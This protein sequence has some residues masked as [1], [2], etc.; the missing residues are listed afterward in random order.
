M[1]GKQKHA[2]FQLGQITLNVTS[3]NFQE[4]NNVKRHKSE[5]SERLA[6]NGNKT[7]VPKHCEHQ[8]H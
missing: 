3:Q 1:L 7:R 6:Y 5:L 8:N 4:A 2:K